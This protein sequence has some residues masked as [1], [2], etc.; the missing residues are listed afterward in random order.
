MQRILSVG[1]IWQQQGSTLDQTYTNLVKPWTQQQ[2]FL[3]EQP[4]HERTT[5][6]LLAAAS[7]GKNQGPSATTKPPVQ[8]TVEIDLSKDLSVQG[9]CAPQQK[10]RT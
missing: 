2:L 9:F 4:Q 1:L 8:Q 3:L 10:H 7:S 5:Q 6:A